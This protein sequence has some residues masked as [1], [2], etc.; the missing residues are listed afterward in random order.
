MVFDF[1]TPFKTLDQAPVILWKTF[2]SNKENPEEI[3]M[4]PETSRSSS[5]CHWLPWIVPC[6]SLKQPCLSSLGFSE[7][8]QMFCSLSKWI[9]S[10]C[11]LNSHI[12]APRSPHQLCFRI[13]GTVSNLLWTWLIFFYLFFRHVCPLLEPHPT[14]YHSNIGESSQTLSWFVNGLFGSTCNI[15][16]M[17]QHGSLKSQ[18]IRTLL[19]TKSAITGATSSHVEACTIY[20]KVAIPVIWIC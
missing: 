18:N 15:S 7:L 20:L 17:K 12:S 2:L 3:N 13:L 5:I 14:M 1:F 8:V 10:P 6:L 16:S 19:G 4:W 11:S 9:W